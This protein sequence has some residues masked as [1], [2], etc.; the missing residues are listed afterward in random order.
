MRQILTLLLIALMVVGVGIAIRSTNEARMYAGDEHSEHA[1]G[2][3]GQDEFERGPHRGR[4][5]RDGDFALEITIFEEGVP[6]EFHVYPYLAGKP[7]PPSDV[8][9][10]IDLGRL[11]T[12]V[13]F[14]G[15]VASFDAVTL[16]IPE[17]SAGLPPLM[18]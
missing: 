10:A 3:A 6:P 2:E 18:P 4:M 5:L 8:K 16:P 1:A 17:V 14:E 13:Q 7:I 12:D 9:L 15:N 11:A